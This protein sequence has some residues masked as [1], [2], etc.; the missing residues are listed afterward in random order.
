MSTL[1][2]GRCLGIATTLAL[3]CGGGETETCRR[4]S[5]VICTVMGN[6][7]RGLG[8]DGLPPSRVM[9][10]LPQDMTEGPDGRLYVLD[11]N[12]H[13]VRTVVDGKTV[14]VVGTGQLGD[15]PDGQAAYSSLNHPTHIVFS[16]TGKMIISAWHN[17]K[18]L[19][20]DTATWSLRRI[21]GTG[22]RAYGGDGGQALDAILDLPV[23]A[24]YDSRG[25]V[26]IM[27]QANQRVRRIDGNGVIDTVAGPPRDYVH[28]PAGF[29]KV[30]ADSPT[31]GQTCKVCRA[32][33][34]SDPACEPFSFKPQ[35]FSGDGGPATAAFLYLPF[36]QS[37]P[38]AGR[39]EMGPGDRLF[40]ADTGNQ[41]IRV[42]EPDG[43]I[44]TVAGSG[45]A[46]Y[47]PAFVGGYAGDGGPATAALLQRPND[48]AVAQDGTFYIADTDNHC[49]RRVDTAGTITTFAGTCGVRGFAGDG[50][51]ARTA[52]LD[53]PYGV[54]LGSRGELYIADTHNHRVRVVYP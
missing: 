32:E 20:V 41:R 8:Q 46:T 18:L 35:G 15:A 30:C 31:G 6:G 3:G 22:A 14:T 1:S 49:V 39:I 7:E 2:W 53:R 23:A 50:G 27:D 11:W 38:P 26:Y 45:P 21:C 54:A 13:R 12:N 19:E 42:L 28:V 4:G 34:A 24:A 44:R 37:A 29:Q 33:Q 40:I 51:P 10:Y 9:L 47:D 25:Q 16:P 17:S 5:G 52:R 43:T 48:V 36:S